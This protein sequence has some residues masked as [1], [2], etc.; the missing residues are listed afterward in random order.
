MRFLTRA[1]QILFERPLFRGACAGTAYIELIFSVPLLA[2]IG[3]GSLELANIYRVQQAISTVS[4]E[5]AN[6]AFRGREDAGE[7]YRKC[8]FKSS[9]AQI[10]SC[11]GSI[12]DSASSNS[13]FALVN[14]NYA[15][16]VTPGAEL[17]LSVF[18]YDPVDRTVALVGQAGVNVN[19]GLTPL[20]NRSR[21]RVP[22]ADA[23]HP[24]WPVDLYRKIPAAEFALTG[25]NSNNRR[26]VVSE[27]F[28]RYNPF[29][30]LRMP[31]YDSD[32]FKLSFYEVTVF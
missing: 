22:P 6:A 27:V 11:L 24:N 29:V 31:G 25:V 1:A 9:R 16:R 30:S 3:F 14:L 15:Q 26:L 5:G 21:F 18:G 7:A 17:L 8:A 2:M 4:W 20:G 23:L 19:S 10:E 13:M 28:Y 12:A 32:M